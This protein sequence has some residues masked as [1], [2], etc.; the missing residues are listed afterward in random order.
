VTD[1]VPTTG[2]ITDVPKL[3]DVI[4]D[5]NR[6]RG[7]TIHVIVFDKQEKVQLGPLAD[8]NGGQCVVMGWTGKQ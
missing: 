7:V 2:K 8:R 6:T 3:I 5:L 1:G 4:T